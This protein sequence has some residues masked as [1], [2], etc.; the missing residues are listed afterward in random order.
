MENFRDKRSIII[1]PGRKLAIYESRPRA[2]EAAT[3]GFTAN[4]ASR[5][6]QHTAGADSC[7]RS[8]HAWQPDFACLISSTLSMSAFPR[9]Y[10]LCQATQARRITEVSFS[11][12]ALATLLLWRARSD[13]VSSALTNVV[14]YKRCSSNDYDTITSRSRFLTLATGC[15][16]A[17]AGASNAVS[18]ALAN[19]VC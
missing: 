2:R 19:V 6:G 3:T 12:S 7:R 4:S 9:G 8:M 17:V 13:A 5:K 18:S 11:D 10:Q 1:S 16:V 14:C 15:T